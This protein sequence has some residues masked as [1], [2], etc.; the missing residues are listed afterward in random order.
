MRLRR[1]AATLW[2]RGAPPPC[3][4]MERDLFVAMM[5]GDLF[6][7]M[8]EGD[9]FVDMMERDLFVALMNTMC[10]GFTHMSAVLFRLLILY[11]Q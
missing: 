2:D 9:L 8:M 4:M 5:E 1:E 10:D 3:D 6:V 7:D 11:S